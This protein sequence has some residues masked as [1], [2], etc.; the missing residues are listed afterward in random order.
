MKSEEYLNLV[1]TLERLKDVTRHCDT[2][3]GRHESVAEHCFRLAAMAYFLKDEFPEADMN[4]VMLMGL[5]HDFGEIFTGDIPCF[6]KT[7]ADEAR[8]NHLLMQWVSALPEPYREEMRALYREMAERK[9]PEAKILYALDGMEAVIQHNE[10]ALDTW[11]AH[12][13]Q[14]QLTHAADRTAFSPYLTELR[15]AIREE[16]EKKTR[17]GSERS[18][19]CA[20]SA[21]A[22]NADAP[23]CAESI[24][25]KNEE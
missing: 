16:T 5:I 21:A 17:S 8:E 22:R 14:L 24:A 4:R 19:L 20:A 9:T 12:E 18:S 23:F 6:S 13:Y 7:K 3:G 1:H 15:Q 11:E 25:I 2:S 10:A